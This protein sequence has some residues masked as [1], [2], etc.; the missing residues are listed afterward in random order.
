VSTDH[1]PASSL[2]SEDVAALA[3][4]AGLT[5]TEER[6]PLITR[7]LNVAN[8]AADDLLALPDTDVAGVAGPFDPAWPVMKRGAK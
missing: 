1:Q 7:E 4:V 8:Q 3:K 6:L 2:N 5:I